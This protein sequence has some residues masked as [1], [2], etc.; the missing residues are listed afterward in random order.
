VT[1]EYQKLATGRQ[2][3]AM[4]VASFDAIPRVFPLPEKTFVLFLA[5]DGRGIPDNALR[6]RCTALLE[7]GAR[8]VCV[9]GPDCSRIHDACDR[10]AG[11]LGLNHDNAVIMST[12][13]EDEPLQEAVWFAANAAFAHQAYAEASN[14]LVAVSVGSVEWESQIREYLQAGTPLPDEA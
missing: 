4:R 2:W 8:Y 10:A 12:W 3:V 11:D 1:Q 6:E 13:H 14:A 7:A 9:W 5:A